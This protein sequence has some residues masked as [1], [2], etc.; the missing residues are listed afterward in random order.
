MPSRRNGTR[1]LKVMTRMSPRPVVTTVPPRVMLS[2][3]VEG[4]KESRLGMVAGE[5]ATEAMVVLGSATAAGAAA[6][7]AAAD[8]LAGAAALAIIAGFTVGRGEPYSDNA[9]A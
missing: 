5:V 1:R 6:V 8:S 2:D 3:G 9:W 7:G 4:T